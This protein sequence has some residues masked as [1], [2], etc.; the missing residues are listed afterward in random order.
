MNKKAITVNG[1]MLDEYL[2]DKTTIK[3]EI[4]AKKFID[5]GFEKV[6]I[7]RLFKPKY[8]QHTEE[9]GKVKILGNLE[10]NIANFENDLKRELSAKK[11]YNCIVIVLTAHS[12][13]LLYETNEIAHIL[14]TFGKK[15]H[16]EVNKNVNWPIRSLLGTLKR[17]KLGQYLEFID[18]KSYRQ[19]TNFGYKK[20][21]KANF[22]TKEAIKLS[23][24][25][26]RE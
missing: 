23:N 15:H 1:V 17:S 4:D 22:T 5:D 19:P 10:I 2:K 3:E 14:K 6:V 18:R 7:K 11:I 21:F 8:K 25:K 16:I 26:L 24:E 13:Q 20:E 12:E 9:N